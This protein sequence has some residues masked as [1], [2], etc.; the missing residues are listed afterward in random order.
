MQNLSSFSRQVH[1]HCILPLN[2]SRNLSLSRTIE[3]RPCIVLCE[4]G[5]IEALA[6][7][8]P[9]VLVSRVRCLC[10]VRSLDSEY[11]VQC[12]SLVDYYCSLCKKVM[13]FGQ[14]FNWI[15]GIGSLD[16]GSKVWT[17]AS[18]SV[19]GHPESRFDHPVSGLGHPKSGLGNSKSGQGCSNSGQT[20]YFG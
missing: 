2:L 7:D 5:L 11:T 13:G 4:I 12:Y 19:L 10:R 15:L 18:E 8:R 1:F 16:L 6:P 20:L 14:I 3:S 17:W 9:S